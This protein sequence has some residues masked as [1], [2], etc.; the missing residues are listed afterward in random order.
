MALVVLALNA[1]LQAAATDRTVHDVNC[2]ST[3]VSVL[4]AS[5][6]RWRRA[7]P[8]HG[9]GPSTDASRCWSPARTSCSPAC[10]SSSPVVSCSTLSHWS[11]SCRAPCVVAPPAGTWPRWLCPTRC[12]SSPSRSTTGSK[13]AGSVCRS[14]HGSTLHRYL[15]LRLLGRIAYTECKGVA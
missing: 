14:A 2:S 12:R 1:S 7:V 3:E 15:H 13:T 8:L 6:A 4:V 9:T 5:K 10:P 11:S